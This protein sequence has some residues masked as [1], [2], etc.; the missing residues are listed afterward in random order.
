MSK[1]VN[2]F[3]EITVKIDGEDVS[4][5]CIACNTEEGWVEMYVMDDNNE[6]I[7]DDDGLRTAKF[8]GNVVVEAGII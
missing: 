1:V 6:F 2:D 8:F 4:R 5:G 7:L 3:I